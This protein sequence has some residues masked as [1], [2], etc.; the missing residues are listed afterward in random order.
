MKKA[1]TKIFE[2][3]AVLVV[4]FFLL[5]IGMVFYARESKINSLAERERG[6]DLQALDVIQVV[7]NLPELQCSSDGIIIENCFD[8]A[9]LESFEELKGKNSQYYTNAFGFSRI[10]I[11]EIYPND[12]NKWEIHNQK[13]EDDR[14]WSS[15]D[16]STIPISILD[17]LDNGQYRAAVLTIEVYR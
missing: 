5:S 16:K 1:Q 10:I 4:F 14:K 15:M 6:Y 8:L 2:T 3:I 13:P 7:S 12:D 17:N 11:D 9:K